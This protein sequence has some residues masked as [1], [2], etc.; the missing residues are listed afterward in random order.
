MNE[1]QLKLIEK[2]IDLKIQMFFRE[3]FQTAHW[4]LSNEIDDVKKQ[5]K[6]NR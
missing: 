2:L 3:L 1:E 5:L 4:E 6:E